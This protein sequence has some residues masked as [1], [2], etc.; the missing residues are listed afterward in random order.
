VDFTKELKEG[1]EKVFKYGIE[2]GKQFI[3]NNF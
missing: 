3:K 2:K 1:V